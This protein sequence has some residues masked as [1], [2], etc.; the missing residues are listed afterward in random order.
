MSTVA[1]PHPVPETASPYMSETII[2]DIWPSVAAYPGPAGLAR[3][4]YRTIILA[5]IGWFVLAPF[6]FMKLLAV[7]P[8]LSGLAK[9]YRLTNRRLMVCKGMNAVCDK[10]VPLNRI[11]DVKLVSD[12]N[13]AFFVAG[14]LEV[15]DTDG[16]TV[17]SLPGVP[18][19]ESVQHAILQAA[20]AWGPVL[21]NS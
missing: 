21:K 11:K 4:C 10:E 9:R 16:Q 12:A 17:M 3:A 15:I 20:A 19:A 13:S 1:D 8:G 2:R 18:E 14:T 5:P 6:Y 7:A